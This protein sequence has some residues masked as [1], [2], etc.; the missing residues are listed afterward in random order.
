MNGARNARGWP[1]AL[2]LL[3]T[4][5]L[6]QALEEPWRQAETV[7]QETSDA[8]LVL[9]DEARGYADEDP[10]RFYVAVE[11]LLEPV[12]D[13]RRFAGSVMATYYKQAT[14]EQRARFADSFKWGL[15]RTYGLALTE[16]EDGEITLVPATKPPRRPDRVSVNQEI[17]TAAGQIYPVV[18]SMAQSKSGE[19]RMR[20]IIVNGVN[21]G[22][23]YRSQF[24][25]AAQ[26]P[27][28]GG[29]LDKV[30]DAWAD[31]LAAEAEKV[32]EETQIQTSSS[33]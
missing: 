26:D 31:V 11:A 19:W 28:Y 18:Y 13:F 5:G 23:T 17:R 4:A 8:M 33:Q 9:I 14:P 12:V 15:V 32:A 2:L 25:S 10:E 29:D 22:L 27:Q 1:L 30:I 21:M 6:V 24:L 20:N 16:F 3:L 7:V